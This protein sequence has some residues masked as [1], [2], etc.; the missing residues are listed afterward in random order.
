[1]SAKQPSVKKQPPAGKKY[2]T[3]AE[4]NA[5][6]PLVRS[7]VQDITNIAHEIGERQERLQRIQPRNNS[8]G[9]A[10]DEELQQVETELDRHLEQLHEYVKEL[11][12]LGV[13]LKDPLLGLIDFRSWMMNREVYLCWKWGEAEVGYWH[14]LEAGFA[15][16]QKLR[17]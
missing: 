11:N 9:S 2:F 13:E 16:R 12:K 1:M 15:G 8:T 4:A 10:Y 14:D 6:L 7:I 5:M 3:V 17:T